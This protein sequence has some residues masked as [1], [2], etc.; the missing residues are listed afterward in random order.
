MADG[1][2]EFND[3]GVLRTAA[4]IGKFEKFMRYVAQMEGLG[5]AFWMCYCL[6]YVQHKNC[7]L[8]VRINLCNSIFWFA[9]FFN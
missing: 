6:L 8:Y 1:S 3:I 5:H 9:T 4:M 7:L 2:D